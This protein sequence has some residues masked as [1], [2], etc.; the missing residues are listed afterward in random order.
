[1]TCNQT[2]GVPKNLDVL[3]LNRDR[4]LFVEFLLGTSID[5][6]RTKFNLKTA[7]EKLRGTAYRLATKK[8]GDAGHFSKAPYKY[9]DLLDRH[10][11][12]DVKTNRIRWME[13]A[14]NEWGGSTPP[15]HSEEPWIALP[16]SQGLDANWHITDE[17]DTFVAHV[18]G[19]GHSVDE[20]SKANAERI[21][22]C[23]NACWG[24]STEELQERALKAAEARRRI[25]EEKDLAE[26]GLPALSADGPGLEIRWFDTRLDA[27]RYA[28]VHGFRQPPEVRRRK[29]GPGQKDWHE[30]W[31]LMVTGALP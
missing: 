2:I 16:P 17:G 28:N 26:S 29:L 22:L 15:A 24:L 14:A 31:S 1:M 6:L 18:F 27:L 13:V 19:M 20:K 4:R 23:V 8:D 5:E 7:D 21:A 11:L 3:A 25:Q 10:S 9:P 12:N 30:G